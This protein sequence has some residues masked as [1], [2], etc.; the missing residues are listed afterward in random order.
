MNNDNPIEAIEQ[1]LQWTFMDL[2]AKLAVFDFWKEHEKG[3]L[4]DIHSI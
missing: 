3:V 4:N 1:N 2:L